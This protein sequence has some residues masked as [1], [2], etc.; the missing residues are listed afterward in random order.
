MTNNQIN[1]ITAK[2]NEHL[3]NG[4][5][6]ITR[7]GIFGNDF[8]TKDG[9]FEAKEIKIAGYRC[10]QITINGSIEEKYY[11]L[12]TAYKMINEFIKNKYQTK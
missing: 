1:K 11:T 12:C 10:Y 6:E 4:L 9:S 8:K 3:K 2:V 5:I 7:S